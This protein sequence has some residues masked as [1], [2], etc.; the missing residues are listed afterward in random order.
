ML[1]QHG[2]GR[3]RRRFQGAEPQCLGRRKQIADTRLLDAAEQRIGVGAFRVLPDEFRDCLIRPPAHFHPVQFNARGREVALRE[4]G[5]EQCRQFLPGAKSVP[6]AIEVHP[7]FLFQSAHFVSR[8]RHRHNGPP[9]PRADAHDH[10]PPPAAA[11]EIVTETAEH[12]V[13]HGLAPGS[14]HFYFGDVSQVS[15]HSQRDIGKRDA[16]ELPG[17]GQ[18]AMPFG[19]KQA[20]GDLLAGEQVPG[21]QRI[22]HGAFVD[23]AEPGQSEPAIDGIV[24]CRTA[25]PVAAQAQIDQVFAPRAQA[26]VGEPAASGEIAE[27]NARVLA[28]AGD[29]FGKQ[30]LAFRTAK[31]DGDGSLALVQS[32]PVQTVAPGVD[33][34]AP[35]VEAAADQVE[36]N[37]V[38]A[39]LSQGHAARRRGDE[40]AAFDHP[41]ALQNCLQENSPGIG[42]FQPVNR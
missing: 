22:V 32:M 26:L 36:A 40:G 6:F 13:A 23:S 35:I 28:G 8:S 15:H 27:E 33:G 42:R 12:V 11:G 19:G 17:S 7:Q 4:P 25:M 20:E 2:R 38:G 31:I 14:V 1:A 3:G 21:R 18:S 37:D 34:P 16:H 41:H 9:L 24:E 30:F 29:Q 10:D 39:E 5:R